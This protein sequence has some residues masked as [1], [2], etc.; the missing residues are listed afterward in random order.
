M[1]YVRIKALIRKE[2][3]QM[4][5]DPSSI[6]TAFIFPL[7]LLFLYGCGVSLD[8]A[9]IKI[10]VVMEDNGPLAQS[11]V[12][13]MRNSKFLDPVIT[14]SRTE[15]EALIAASKIKGFVVIP[16]QFTQFYDSPFETA[17]IQ[18]ISDGSE[19]N[20]AQFVQ[21]YVRE[22]WSTWRSLQ[23]IENARIAPSTVQVVGRMWYNEEVN[24]RYFLVPGSIV[25]IMT[26][27]GAMLTAM[28]VAREW[29]RGTME[30]V[31]STPATMGEILFS[32]FIS[33]FILG[34]GSLALCFFVAQY[35]Y[36]VP[37]RG[38]Y[39]GLAA[40]AFSYL[41]FALGMGLLISFFARNQF[42][43][44]QVAIV[45]TYLPSFI[46]SGFIFDIES[47]PIYLRVLTIFVPARYFVENLK[48]LFLVGDVWSLCLP[49]IAVMLLFSCLIFY[50]IAKRSIKRLD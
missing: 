17:P 34:T 37:F 15:A 47:M 30:A 7:I 21:N 36:G 50:L 1:N 44:S 24:S 41:I 18:V 31:M 48:T 13:S 43:A 14:L 40:S 42:A 22:A 4:F 9:N 10:A 46:L 49:N 35:L 8:M 2:S 20:T 29:E 32:K 6:V 39:L 33:Y 38:T 16:K 45:S 28:V 12:I 5:K 27:T 19:P 26:I 23:R 25:V 3:V 11:F